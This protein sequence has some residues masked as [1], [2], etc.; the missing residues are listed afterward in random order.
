MNRS[1]LLVLSLNCKSLNYLQVRNKT[2]TWLAY[3]EHK[4]FVPQLNYDKYGQSKGSPHVQERFFRLGWGG[5]IH[6]QWERRLWTYKK[7]D[8]QNKLED[9]H[10]M[11][12]NRRSKI[13]DKMCD[14]KYRKR[15]YLVD[16]KYKIYDSYQRRWG[17]NHIYDHE[18]D[19]KSYP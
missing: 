6:P 19:S 7:P 11:V 5:Y 8:E 2:H 10:V 14:D 12:A 9:Q 4:T 17:M 18:R 3:K 13:L 15:L 16:Q 1:L